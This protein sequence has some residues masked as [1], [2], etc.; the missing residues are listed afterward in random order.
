MQHY[1]YDHHYCCCTD[2]HVHMEATPG[3]EVQQQSSRRESAGRNGELI[4]TNNNPEQTPLRENADIDYDYRLLLIIR[5][6]HLLLFVRSI[7]YR[8][9]LPGTAPIECCVPGTRYWYEYQVCT[10]YQVP[11]TRT[12]YGDCD[13]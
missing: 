8:Y 13:V 6:Q 9:T 3:E 12:R 4:R 2:T 11:G 7:P 10:R 1:E 5:V